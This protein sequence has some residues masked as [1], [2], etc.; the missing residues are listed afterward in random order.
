MNA[1]HTYF[2]WSHN[3]FNQESLIY[4]PRSETASFTAHQVIDH[5][6]RKVKCVHYFG[7]NTFHNILREKQKISE[8]IKKCV[9]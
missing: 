1:Y 3:V 8:T 5:I 2:I 9:N 7:M 6:E 4:S